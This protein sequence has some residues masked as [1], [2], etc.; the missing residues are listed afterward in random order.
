MEI[1]ARDIINACAL[2]HD[3][4]VEIKQMGKA[5]ALNCDE[6]FYESNTKYLC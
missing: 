4:V 5:F 6:D 2:M 1:Y 3:T